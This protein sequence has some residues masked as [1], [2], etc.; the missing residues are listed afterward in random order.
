MYGYQVSKR[1]VAEW[2]GDDALEAYEQFVT[3]L[4][5]LGYPLSGGRLG[6]QEALWQ[7]LDN[8]DDLLPLWCYGPVSIKVVRLYSHV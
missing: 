3:L 4:D 1:G 5:T 8:G 6:F 7:A 2:C